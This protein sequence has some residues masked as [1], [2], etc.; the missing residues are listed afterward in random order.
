MAWKP[1]IFQMCPAS[2]EGCQGSGNDVVEVNRTSLC[3]KS[4]ER[5]LA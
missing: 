2:I 3:P 1:N 5:T 4:N